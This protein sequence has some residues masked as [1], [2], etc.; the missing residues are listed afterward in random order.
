M[1]RGHAGDLFPSLQRKVEVI[2]M[3]MNEV[4]VLGLAE[5]PFDHQNVVGERVDAIGIEPE[6]FLARRNQAGPRHR[7]AAS[8]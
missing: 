6:R 8:K 3:K 7:I 4:K 2:G 5:N 1:Q